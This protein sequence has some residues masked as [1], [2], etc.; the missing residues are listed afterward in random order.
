MENMKWKQKG[1]LLLVTRLTPALAGETAKPQHSWA[2]GRTQCSVG[3]DAAIGQ[4][5]VDIT[6][7]ELKKDECYGDASSS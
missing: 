3:T 2:F 7:Q 4:R 5:N 6:E 1:V